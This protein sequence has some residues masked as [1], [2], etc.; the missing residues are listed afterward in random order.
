MI[1]V[2]KV[3]DGDFEPAMRGYVITKGG[4]A[5]DA[6]AGRAEAILVEAAG[7]AGNR[8][9]PPSAARSRRRREG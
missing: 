4:I 1:S 8:A 9:L 5:V 3:R 2:I 6:D 7:Q